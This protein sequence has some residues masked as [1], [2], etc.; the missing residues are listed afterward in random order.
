MTAV[1]GETTGEQ[2]QVG[3]QQAAAAID[4]AVHHCLQRERVMALGG[5]A[6]AAAAALNMLAPPLLRQ[7]RTVAPVPCSCLPYVVAAAR[8]QSY[9]RWSS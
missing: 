1:G 3:H 5:L 6:A 9:P 8:W 4:P 7:Q 2:T